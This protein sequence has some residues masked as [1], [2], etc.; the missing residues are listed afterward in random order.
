MVLEW[1]ASWVSLLKSLEEWRLRLKNRWL[2]T[3]HKTSMLKF[4]LLLAEVERERQRPLDNVLLQLMLLGKYSLGSYGVG[5]VRVVFCVGTYVFIGGIV[6]LCSGTMVWHKI[7]SRPCENPF[8]WLSR[9]GLFKGKW[10][11]NTGTFLPSFVTVKH[12]YWMVRIG[13]KGKPRWWGCLG[14]DVVMPPIRA[15]PSALSA[16]L[17]RHH[18][19]HPKHPNHS[20]IV[21]QKN[22]TKEGFELVTQLPLEYRQKSNLR[23]TYLYRLPLPCTTE[24]EQF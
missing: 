16:L 6:K 19:I 12:I 8:G 17:G 3:I 10:H 4:S 24:A 1:S 23:P 13:R 15:G 20:L 11:L 18:N 22:K 7:L 5:L 9:E 14:L 2:C 21:V